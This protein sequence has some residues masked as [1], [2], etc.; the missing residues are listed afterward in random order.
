M[1]FELEPTVD[2]LGW[3]EDEVERS[4]GS[5]FVDCAGCVGDANTWGIDGHRRAS[6]R[7]TLGRKCHGRTPFS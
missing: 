5:G 1:I 7:C 6:I 3:E 2:G 4:C